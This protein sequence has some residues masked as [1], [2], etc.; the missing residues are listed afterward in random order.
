MRW[1]QLK[2]PREV[3]ASAKALERGGLKLTLRARP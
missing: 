1:P 2:P 3:G